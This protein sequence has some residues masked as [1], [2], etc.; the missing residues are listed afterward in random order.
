[1]GAQLVGLVVVKWAHLPA[2]PYKI[3]TRMALTA[4]DE[5]GGPDKPAATFWAGWEVLALAIGRELPDPHDE[6]GEA[7]KRRK[8][9]R[10]EVVRVTTSLQDAG[11]IKSVVDN[12]GSGWR[13]VWKV[14]P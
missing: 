9:I 3:L 10:D 6:G 2:K 14:T 8:T 7:A 4:R 1:M 11:A 5:E 13:Q 12:P